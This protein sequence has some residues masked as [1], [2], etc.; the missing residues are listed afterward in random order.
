MSKTST[1]HSFFLLELAVHFVSLIHLA[2]LK[3]VGW[4]DGSLRVW[5][6]FWK[7]LIIEKALWKASIIE[8][9]LSK[10]FIIEKALSKALIIE[11]ALS[12]AS[13]IEKALSIA[14]I[15]EKA[16]SKAS[17]IKKALWKASIIQ[18]ASK[19]PNQKIPQQSS[20]SP[21]IFS[22]F[23]LLSPQWTLHVITENYHL[24]C[25]AHYD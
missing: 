22:A 17:I 4:I 6:D 7:A 12:K 25:A 13:I 15:I 1:V 16:L 23:S 18:I 14:F 19:L 11:K 3:I 8:K 5:R 10:A 2:L 24:P 21:Q 9:T 20:P